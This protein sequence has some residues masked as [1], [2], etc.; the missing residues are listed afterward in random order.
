MAVRPSLRSELAP[1][2]AAAHHQGPMSG[3]RPRGV[4]WAGR[5]GADSVTLDHYRTALGLQ[6]AP[7]SP[8]ID[9]PTLSH[10]A[11]Q[12]RRCDSDATSGNGVVAGNSA[13]TRRYGRTARRLTN[14]SWTHSRGPLR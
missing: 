6:A 5:R 8:R 7:T 3:A 9:S 12:R 10:S 11:K 13:A 4:G 1:P 14:M 2:C